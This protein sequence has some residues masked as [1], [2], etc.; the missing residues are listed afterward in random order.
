MFLKLIYCLIFF[1]NKKFTSE[2]YDYSLNFA[3]S[4]SNSKIL[5]DCYSRVS[6]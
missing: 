6:F 1:S 2:I 4:A 5:L 3:I